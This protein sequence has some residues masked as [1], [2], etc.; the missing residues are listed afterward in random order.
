MLLNSLRHFLTAGL[1]ALLIS[2]AWA[3]CPPMPQAA[4]TPEQLAAAAPDRG[5]L[6]RLTRDGRSAYLFASLHVGRPE[7][8]YPGPLL[9]EA[10]AHSELIALELD[11]ADAETQRLLA[12]G[13]RHADALRLDAGTQARLQAQARAA[14]LPEQALAALHPLLQLATLSLLAGRWE[15]LDA[16]YG[17]ELMLGRWAAEQGRPIAALENADEQLRALVPRRAAPAL[18]ALRQGLAQLEDG[19]LRPV[20]RRLAAAWE[21]GDLAELADYTRWCECVADAADRAELK[22]LNDDRN[23]MLAARIAALHARGQTLLAAVGALHMTGPQ[24]LPRLLEQQG[25]VVQALHPA[26]A[27]AGQ[28]LPSPR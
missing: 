26:P 9:R 5:M 14:C 25:F 12:R 23:P 2:P 24:A 19:S 22:R 17:Q 1:A 13:P 18:R 21:R 7:W 20:L 16:A 11:L 3:Q 6:W 15:G 27:G 10:L 4:A 28:G 8:A